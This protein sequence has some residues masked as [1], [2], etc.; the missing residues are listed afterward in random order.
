M[1]FKLGNRSS[2]FRT[3]LNKVNHTSDME[4]DIA[5]EANLDGSINV[6]SNIPKDSAEYKRVMR[7]ELQHKR[8]MESGRASYGENH[9]VWE[10]NIYFR[11]M[12]DG[13]AFID[14]PAGRLPEGHPDHPWEMVAIAAEQTNE[15]DSEIAKADSGSDIHGE[16]PYPFVIGRFALGGLSNVIGRIKRKGKSL[17]KE[18]KI[19]LAKEISGSVGGGI[20]IGGGMLGVIGGRIRNKFKK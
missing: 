6:S 19:E 11:R 4:R 7:H 5:G 9:V 3:P 16:S 17:S 20:G 15:H 13:Q 18:E 2:L 10:G 1:A 8:D 12:I 14:G